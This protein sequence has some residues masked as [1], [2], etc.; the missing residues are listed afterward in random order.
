MIGIVLRLDLLVQ[1]SLSCRASLVPNRLHVINRIDRQTVSIRAIADRQLERRVDVALL[2]VPAYKQIL[3]ALST[4]CQAVNEPWV[5]VEVEN[6]GL[7]ISK[8]GSPLVR[9]QPVRV[10][11]G[12]DELEQI[13]DIDEA[14]LQLGQVLSEKCGGC[15]GFMG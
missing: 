14:D 5:R 10:F 3:L 7:I 8:N 12:I 9:T 6:A 11:A 15:E 2:P 13:D 1:Q 4:V